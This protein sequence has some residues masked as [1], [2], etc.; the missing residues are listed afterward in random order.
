MPGLAGKHALLDTYPVHDPG[1]NWRNDMTKNHPMYG[2]RKCHHCSRHSW[3]VAEGKPCPWCARTTSKHH[4]TMNHIMFLV[5][6]ASIVA[7]VLGLSIGKAEAKVIFEPTLGCTMDD[8]HYAE[9][10]G[11]R[12][13][14][15][16]YQAL[17]MEIGEILQARYDQSWDDF[18]DQRDLQDCL[19]GNPYG[20]TKARC[21]ELEDRS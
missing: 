6:I 11:Y 16:A 17:G 4:H 19:R 15:E 18:K 9:Y 2:T 13:L 20:P 1:F 21:N 8:V 7:V 3:L 12:K 14:I 5:A 10:D